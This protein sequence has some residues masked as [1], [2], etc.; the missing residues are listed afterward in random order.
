MPFAFK[1][2]AKR[3]APSPPLP[4]PNVLWEKWALE[5]CSTSIIITWYGEM[6]G[7]WSHEPLLAGCHPLLDPMLDGWLL[8]KLPNMK[9]ERQHYTNVVRFEISDMS[10]PHSLSREMASTLCRPKPFAH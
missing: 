1:L 10:A 3:Q 8:W 5:Q 7:L 9:E 2:I 4:H 6:R